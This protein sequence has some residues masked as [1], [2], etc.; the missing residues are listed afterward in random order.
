MARG[1]IQA[2]LKITDLDLQ[3]SLDAR[4]VAGTARF[5]KMTERQLYRRRRNLEQKLS[6]AIVV[7]R[8]NRVVPQTLPERH[9]LTVKDG[10]VIVAGDAHYWPGDVPLMHRALVK[11]IKDLRPKAIVMNGDICDF[12]SISR[13]P[14]V[15]WE[16]QPTVQ[17]EIEVCQDRL[18]EIERAAGR[19]PKIWPLGNHDARFSIF[20]ARQAPEF[21]K[22]AG[23]RL[24]DHFPLW[25]PC[26][27]ACIN[28]NTIIKHR[29]KGGLHAAH[30][31]A[32]SSG[33]NIIT[34]HLHSGKVSPV[35][36]YTGTR[37]GVDTGCLAD[38]HSKA[39][40]YLQDDPRNWREGF[41]VLTYRNGDLIMPELVTKWDNN[42]VQFRG[43]IIK[44]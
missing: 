5:F 15:N 42:N 22:V 37:Y 3:K 34:N 13:H 27:S 19:I 1:E 39:F 11:F 7:G 41:A 43:E 25:E 26:W 40:L 24:A 6:Q 16:K 23:T 31:N 36:D 35:T 8:G 17:E 28:S 18:S 33:V 38:I 9:D 44:V 32:V 29:L 30:N 10:I 4:G 12:A 14:V 2:N 21:G 20:L